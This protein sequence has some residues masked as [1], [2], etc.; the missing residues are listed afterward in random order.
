MKR[1]LILGLVALSIGACAPASARS[2]E[3]TLVIPIHHSRF[4]IESIRVDA[5][6]TV[7]FV[8]R[9][10]DPIDHE[11]IL[12]NQDVQDRHEG[13]TEGHHGTVPGEV[14]IPPHSEATMTYS[15]GQPATLI[16]ACHLPGH[17]AY[18]MSG[19]VTVS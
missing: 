15:F 5:G 1:S 4:G 18:G 10:E 9:N 16:F 13:G 6:S 2:S 14:S 19:I 17:F 8:I 12:G 7:R 3:R 11:F